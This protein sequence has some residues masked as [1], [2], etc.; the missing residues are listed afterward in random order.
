MLQTID[1]A[2]ARGERMLFTRLNISLSG[3]SLLH[4]LGANGSGKTS[5]LRTLCGLLAPAQ[6]DILWNGQP[7]RLL[8]D[9]Y[10]SA[11][12]YLGHVNAIKDDLNAIENLS[13]TSRIAGIEVSSEK[14]Y[15][16]LKQMGVASCDQLPVKIL[17]QGQKRRIALARLLLTKSKFWL[18][19]E[20]FAA[21]DQT[22]SECLRLVIAAHLAQDGIVAI[23][24]HQELN[25]AADSVQ[26]LQLGY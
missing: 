2:C 10:R 7:I 20:P 1:L 17:S 5:L 23:T 6:G 24:S 19:D 26:R 25:I 11:I 22:A 21:L 9:V 4:I 16:A 15:D 18:L 13:F 8:G 3:G 12:S 14:V